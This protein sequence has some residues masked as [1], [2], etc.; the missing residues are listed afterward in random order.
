MID[1]AGLRAVA[2]LIA[3]IVLGVTAIIAVLAAAYVIARSLD[4]GTLEAKDALLYLT[5]MFGGGATG[6]VGLLAYTL[7]QG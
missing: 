5:L 3:V 7:R 6:A 2:G 1:T 4:N